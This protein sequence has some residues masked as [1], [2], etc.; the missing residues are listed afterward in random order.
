MALKF[1]SQGNRGGM[2]DYTLTSPDESIKVTEIT[3]GHEI[4]VSER[5][6]E[7]INNKQDKMIVGG[8]QTN[9]IYS[10]SLIERDGAGIPRT[11]GHYVPLLEIQSFNNSK[12]QFEF[13]IFSREDSMNYYARYLFTTSTSLA[14]KFE[15]LDYCL[16][17]N[18]NMIPPTFRFDSIVAFKIYNSGSYSRFLICKE[19]ISD[20]GV[21]DAYYF[22]ILSQDIGFCYSKKYYTR[23]EQSYYTPWE[24]VQNSQNYLTNWTWKYVNGIN[25]AKAEYELPENENTLHSVD[26]ST[27]TEGNGGLIKPTPSIIKPLT[28]DG[29]PFYGT[30][31]RTI[32][33]KE[34]YTGD[35]IIGIDPNPYETRRLVHMTLWKGSELKNFSWTDLA[36]IN[37]STIDDDKIYWVYEVYNDTSQ[38]SGYIIETPNNFV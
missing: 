34:W 3:N 11:I 37:F 8:Y 27:L 26:L 1:E 20:A 28:I 38:R 21:L 13:S 33:T 35:G 5:L 30:T 15:L 36:F 2:V 32:E 10:M 4:E 25:T 14:P 23:N 24:F 17:Q 6:K 16:D 18:S 29:E 22:N 12:S 9:A 19:I 31:P 7:T